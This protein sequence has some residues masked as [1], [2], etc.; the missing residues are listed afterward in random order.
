VGFHW[1]NPLHGLIVLY[2]ARAIDGFSGGNV[3]TAQAYVSDVTTP[4]NRAKGMGLIGAAFGLGFTLGPWLGGELAAAS[5]HAPGLLAA[6]LSFSAATFGYLKLPEPARQAGPRSS[7][8]FGF[9]QVRGAFSDP[10]LG[11]L[12]VLSFLFITSFSAFE[13]MFTLFGIQRFPSWFGL[14]NAI[15]DPTHVDALR[16]APWAGRYMGFIGLI[17]AFIQGGLI[18]RLVPRYG[19][20]T[21]AFVGPLLLSVSMLVVGLATSWWVVIAGCVLMPFGFGLNNPA[22]F[23]LISRASPSEEQGAYL[24]LNQS[25]LSLARMVGPSFAGLLF[26]RV[27]ARAPFLVSAATLGCCALVAWAYR[28]R[29]AAT[30][31]RA[32]D[33]AP[34][35]EGG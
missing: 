4:E 14:E 17:A 33:A 16:A 20:T 12:L 19:E 2:V 22:L 18:R 7:R 24:G 11:V 21:L 29:Y 26:A 30:F 6:A 34:A 9:D 15:A 5:V 35:A 23:G 25:I 13:S 28:A 1:G 32:R 31:P 27:G 3:S 8:I 10:R